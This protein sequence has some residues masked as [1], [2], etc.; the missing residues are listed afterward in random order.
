METNESSNIVKQSTTQ[1]SR[2]LDAMDFDYIKIDEQ[3]F[4]CPNFPIYNGLS[5]NTK[6]AA[7]VQH[8]LFRV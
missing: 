5:R 3:S 6:R 8:P 4:P 2:F 1:D 7:A